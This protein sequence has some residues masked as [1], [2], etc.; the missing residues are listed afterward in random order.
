[1]GLT[2]LADLGEF[3]GG[4]AVVVAL[5]A[6][7]N[8]IGRGPLAAVLFWPGRGLALRWSAVLRKTEREPVLWDVHAELLEGAG[9]I[10]EAADARAKAEE[11]RS[12]RR[13]G[14]G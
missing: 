14:G 8:R 4:I 10:T 7:R 6:F 3:I 11:I 12:G 5:F 1:M 9:R 2:Q 13:P